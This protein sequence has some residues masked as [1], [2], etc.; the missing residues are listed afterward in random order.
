MDEKRG[1]VLETP[2]LNI[3]NFPGKSKC[4]MLTLKGSEKEPSQL[5]RERHQQCNTYLHFPNVLP[6]TSL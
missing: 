3:P 2:F 1:L 4:L 5:P 6:T